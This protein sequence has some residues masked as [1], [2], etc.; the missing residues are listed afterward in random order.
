MRQQL[1][2]TLLLSGGS[3]PVPLYRQISNADQDWNRVDIAPVDERWV[4]A[5]SDASIEGLFRENLLVNAAV[6]AHFVGMKNSRLAP[7]DGE[8]ECNAR[9]AGLASP[10]TI[11]LLGMGVDGHT[12]SLFPR[13][14]GLA[15]AHDSKRPCAAI[16]A[17]R[18]ELTG[19]NVAR[20]TMTP[21]SL[22]QSRRLLLLITGADK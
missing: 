3:T 20:M 18:A 7:F 15:A 4:D 13:A 22:F 1:P 6:N 8:T 12:A 2:V 11:G 16:R 19:E 14:K 21:W 5:Q 9:Y 17:L 10:Y